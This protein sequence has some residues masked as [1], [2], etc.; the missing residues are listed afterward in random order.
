[1]TQISKRVLNKDI[2][3]K[4]TETFLA[5]I[6]QVRDKSEVQLFINDLLTPVERVMLAKRFAI[7]VLLIKGWGYG[8]I[9]DLLKV[10]NDTI[11]R[12]SLVLKGNVGYKEAVERLVRT[13]AGRAF[14]RDVASFVYRIG[15]PGRVFVDE[16]L[17]RHKLGLRKKSLL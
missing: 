16:E 10:S 2:E 6:S 12:V 3:K 15:S 1:M 17:I 7:A 14:W 13:E 11:S 4:I 5:V 8:S 9:E